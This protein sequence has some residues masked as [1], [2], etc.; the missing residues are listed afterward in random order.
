MATMLAVET[1]VSGKVS[2]NKPLK[3]HLK[4]H[5]PDKESWEEDLIALVRRWLKSVVRSK[6]PQPA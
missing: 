6:P 4:R 3:K 2:F 1:K 5:Y